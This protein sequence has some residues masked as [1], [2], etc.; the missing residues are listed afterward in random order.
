MAARSWRN[1]PPV[2]DP[3]LTER[4]LRHSIAALRDSPGNG[5]LDLLD[6]RGGF[7]ILSAGVTPAG[8]L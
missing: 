5:T 1:V 6:R 8:S 3:T 2:R 4:I 7:R